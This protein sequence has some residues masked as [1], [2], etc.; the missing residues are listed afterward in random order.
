MLSCV[1]HRHFY[2]GVVMLSEQCEIS[3]ILGIECC[4]IALVTSLP[5]H[6]GLNSDFVKLLCVRKLKKAS[7]FPAERRYQ[8]NSAQ[9]WSACICVKA[10]FGLPTCVLTCENGATLASY[11]AL[12]LA[13]VKYYGS[14]CT[15]S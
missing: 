11:G 8:R 4:N 14:T 2:F 5:L 1:F 15:L 7:G 6:H 3:P 13:V 12:Q 9:G 10:C